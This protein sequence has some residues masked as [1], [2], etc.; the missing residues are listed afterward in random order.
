MVDADGATEIRD[1]QDLQD[2]LDKMNPSDEWRDHTGFVMGSRTKKPTVDKAAKRD[3]KRNLAMHAFHMI[4]AVLMVSDIED[5]QCGFKLFTRRSA[6]LLFSQQ[7]IDRWA[8]DV[9][10]CFLAHRLDVQMREVQVNWEEIPGGT[11]DIV[12]DGIRMALD[13]ASARLMYTLSFWSIELED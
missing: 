13:M 2:E 4:V 6:R 12:W 9:E 8:F 5:T 1:L 7:H 10:L 3:F 11:I